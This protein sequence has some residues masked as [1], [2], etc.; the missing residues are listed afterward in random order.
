MT[1]HPVSAAEFI[2]NAERTQWHDQALWFVRAK[3]DKA[4]RTVPEWELLRETASQ[5]KAHTMTR[6]PEY[7]EEFERQA[8]RLGA[9]VHWARDG[10]EHNQIVLDILQ[11]HGAKH[12]VK[13]KSMLTEECHLNPCLE[14]HGIEVVDTDL[15]ER[16][17]QFRHEPP[18]HIVLPAIHLKKE[19]VGVLFHERLG[20]TAGATDPKYLTE[21]ARQHLREKF[22]GADAGLSGVNFGVAETG[23]VVVCTNE[24]N[25]DLGVSLPK[26][27]IA[28]MGIEKLIPRAKDLGVFLRLLARSATGQPITTYTSHFHGPIR[29]GELHIVLVDNGRSRIHA[30]ETFH[31]ALHCIRCGAC[32]NTCPVYRRSGGYSY[33]ATIPGPIGSVL[34]P[35]RDA[36]QHYSLPY[37]CSLCGSCSD[38]CPVKIPLAD[39]LLAWRGEIVRRRLLPWQKRLAMKLGSVVLRNTWIY[40]LAGKM[41]RF[42]LPKMPR[43]ML[44]H[45][46]NDWGKQ[47]ELPPFPKRSF[48]ELYREQH[49]QHK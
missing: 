39:Q 17:V 35:L 25:A 1:S 13:S 2:A 14:E 31:H 12:V 9:Q 33:H 38:V 16:I 49:D 42:F 8:T 32:L 4:A 27:H 18:S 20:T 6:L 46:L 19:E 28:C 11:R 26:L 23:G 41:A 43:W 36:P 30:D 5:I 10:A 40:N 7:L 15:G 21:A 34:G 47:R 37:A 48:R 45:R 22:L 29:G 24:G 3:R 44:Y